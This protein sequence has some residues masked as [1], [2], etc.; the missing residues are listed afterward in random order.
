MATAT[1]RRRDRGWRYR[2]GLAGT[3]RQRRHHVWSRLLGYPAVIHARRP[4]SVHPRGHVRADRK[5]GFPV[6]YV[7]RDDVHGVLV[8]L[9]TRVH[10]RRSAKS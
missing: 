2:D 1:D 8:H 4:R 10:Q 7:G 3:L 6:F 5:P 9:F